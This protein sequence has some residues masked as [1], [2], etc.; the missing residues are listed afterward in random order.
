[1]SRPKTLTRAFERYEKLKSKRVVTTPEE[2]EVLSAL[3]ED[4]EQPETQA[5]KEDREHK[6]CFWLLVCVAVAVLVG[7]MKW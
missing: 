2:I 7:Y 4:K 6:T 5:K 3:I 1:M